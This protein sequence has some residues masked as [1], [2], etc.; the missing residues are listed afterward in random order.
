MSGMDQVW[1]D[2]WPGSIHNHRFIEALLITQFPRSSVCIAHH[3]TNEYKCTKS[4]AGSAVQVLMELTLM[5]APFL[6]DQSDLPSFNARVRPERKEP[7]QA[8][9]S[10]LSQLVDR[11]IHW[12]IKTLNDGISRSNR[13]EGRKS[14][15]GEI[16]FGLSPPHITVCDESGTEE[17]PVAYSVLYIYIDMGGWREVMKRKRKFCLLGP[18]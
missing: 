1:T 16:P 5:G 17:R 18:C 15:L 4:M 3:H 6:L 14:E 11:V 9:N 2:V 8:N 7:G 10:F 13:L 12:Y